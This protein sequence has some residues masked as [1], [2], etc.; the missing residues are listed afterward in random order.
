MTHTQTRSY[1]HTSGEP[2][3]K[4]R[5]FAG[6]ERYSCFQAVNAERLFLCAAYVGCGICAGILLFLLCGER[7][8]SDTISSVYWSARAFTSYSS[9]IE[10]F[11][12]L[13]GWFWH[14]AGWLAAAC[15]FA[16]TVHPQLFCGILGFFRGISTAFGICVLSGTFSAFAIYDAVMQSAALAL[17][18]MMSAKSICHA[19]ERRK[20]TQK[21]PNTSLLNPSFLWGAALP[22][23]ANFLL[24]A[25]TLVTGQLI[26]SAAACFFTA[27]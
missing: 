16:M 9:P 15:F 2:T 14:H 22:L 11:T 21:D 5:F 3:I 24:C 6:M 18:L 19:E 27:P 10:Y 12:F 26:I 1:S 17:L 23:C 13:A 4:G 25:G 20:I 8:D 7:A